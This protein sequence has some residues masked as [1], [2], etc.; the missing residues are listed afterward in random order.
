MQHPV[1]P[2]ILATV[3]HIIYIV[4][5]NL[6]KMFSYLEP[7]VRAKMLYMGSEFTGIYF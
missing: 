3:A 7:T 2:V 5:V 6:T 1:C 4:F